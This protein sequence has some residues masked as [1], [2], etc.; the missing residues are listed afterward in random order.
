MGKVK[1]NLLTQKDK[2]EQRDKARSLRNQK[3]F[4]KDVQKQAKVKKQEDR[5]VAKEEIKTIRKKGEKFVKGFDDVKKGVEKSP[6]K[7][8]IQLFE[9]I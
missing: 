7:K 9:T 8:V 1:A 5:R 4:A 2:I 3:K 6:M